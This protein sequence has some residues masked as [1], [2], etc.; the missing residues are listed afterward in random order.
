[1]ST[2]APVIFTK[3]VTRGKPQQKEPF[4]EEIP[5]RKQKA[6]KR[7]KKMATSSKNTATPKKRA[8]TPALPK[9]PIARIWTTR[10][11]ASAKRSAQLDRTRKC[12]PPRIEPA[13][14]RQNA[15][16]S[17]RNRK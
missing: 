4:P 14:P 17:P 6:V 16:S 3:M 11:S 5:P 1:M 13:I 15:P 7:A 2:P 9:S 10:G 8:R 12:S